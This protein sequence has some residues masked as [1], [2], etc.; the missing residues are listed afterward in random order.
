MN[1]AA[2]QESPQSRKRKTGDE[3]APEAMAESES[4]S[5]KKVAA[6]SSRFRFSSISAASQ[7]IRPRSENLC[8]ADSAV[9]NNVS[10]IQ[11]L[12][13][14]LVPDMNTP[15]V[16]FARRKASENIVDSTSLQNTSSIHPEQQG[17]NLAQLSSSYS[18]LPSLIG[19]IL[20]QQQILASLLPHIEAPNTTHSSHQQQENTLAKLSSSI[21]QLTHS[22]GNPFSQQQQQQQQRTL[23]NHLPSNSA[24]MLQLFNQAGSLSGLQHS[25][26]QQATSQAVHQSSQRP[27]ADILSLLLPSLSQQQP[28]SPATAEGSSAVDTQVLLSALMNAMSSGT[29]ISPHLSQDADSGTLSLATPNDCDRKLSEYQLLLRQQLEFFVAQ[30]SDVDSSTQ[31]R[32][33]QVHLGQVGLRCRHCA[34]IP[35]RERERGAVYYP[36]KLE[37]VYQAAQNMASTHLMESCKHIDASIRRELQELRDRK[38]TAI[39]GKT[40][41]AEACQEMGLYEADENGLRLSLAFFFPFSHPTQN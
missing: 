14:I 31:G 27:A 40:Q 16:S 41:W 6:S 25:I 11:Q 37:S 9:D 13:K 26:S 15:D 4:S 28:N 8:S 1:D 10:A 36:A 34:H 18:D 20:S 24:M 23:A 32:R 3:T 12:L 19:N 38:H 33:K 21:S 39:G 2:A 5:D 30:H 17:R 35:L 7:D 22:Q 29:T